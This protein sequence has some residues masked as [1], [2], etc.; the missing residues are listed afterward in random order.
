MM[1]KKMSSFSIYQLENL[2]KNLIKSQISIYKNSHFIYKKSKKYPGTTRVLF[3][4]TCTRFVLVSTR[5]RVKYPGTGTFSV[6]VTEYYSL[7]EGWADLESPTLC[8]ADKNTDNTV[9]D[10]EDT[11]AKRTDSRSVLISSR[12]RV[13]MRLRS[14]IYHTKRRISLTKEHDFFKAAKLSFYDL[15]NLNIIESII[16]FEDDKRTHALNRLAAFAFA[17]LE[18]A[19][20]QCFVCDTEQD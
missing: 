12:V 8:L 17:S 1:L 3:L 6:T 19:I 11:K 5:T 15:M 18:R 16:R 13:R 20:Q 14:S 2:I 4:S 7:F 9:I 10:I